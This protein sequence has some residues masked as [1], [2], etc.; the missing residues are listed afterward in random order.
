M[1]L[2]A[3]EEKF[4]AFQAKVTM[5]KKV[6]EEE[7]EASGDVIFNYGYGCYAF[8]HNVCGSESMIPAGMPDTIKPLP[9]EFFLST[10]DAP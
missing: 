8:A 6:M 5:E 9:P 1:E 3:S 2:K 10:P 7:F 4:S